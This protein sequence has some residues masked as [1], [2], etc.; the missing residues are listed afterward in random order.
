[1]V[2]GQ[3]VC[4]QSSFCAGEPSMT[5]G[6]LIKSSSF[7][8]NLKPASLNALPKSFSLG[9]FTWQVAHDVPY[10]LENAGIAYSLLQR[11]NNRKAVTNGLPRSFECIALTSA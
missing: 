6:I 3:M 2:P 11:S 10:C 4:G 8:G 7:L 1:M 5:G 9:K